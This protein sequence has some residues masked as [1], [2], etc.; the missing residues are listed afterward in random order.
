[1]SLLMP[2]L[3]LKSKTS[4]CTETKA[5]MSSESSLRFVLTA[6]KHPANVTNCSK[7]HKHCLGCNDWCSKTISH[8]SP[9]VVT[10]RLRM[11]AFVQAGF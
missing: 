4:V 11:P 7:A 6:C 8:S 5:A 3:L 1:M 9:K 2:V 10:A